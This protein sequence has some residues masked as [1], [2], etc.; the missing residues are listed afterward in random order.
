MTGF[1]GNETPFV[2]DSGILSYIDS[3]LTLRS[4]REFPQ[5]GNDE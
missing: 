3:E 5:T 2:A 1:E 4:Y